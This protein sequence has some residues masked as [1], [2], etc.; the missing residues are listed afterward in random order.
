MFIDLNRVAEHFEGTK[1][2]I[3]ETAKTFSLTT[4]DR[5]E[6]AI[7]PYNKHLLY[8]CTETTPVDQYKFLPHMSLL[9]T[10]R[11]DADF[12][13]IL[14]RFPDN[15]NVM[16]IQAKQDNDFF[17]T[18][19]DYFDLCSG[20]SMIGNTFLEI[21]SF[22][23][24]IQAM[25]DYA[26]LAFD[27]PVFVFDANFTLIAANWEEAQKHPA[28][29]DIINN[30]GFSQKD[31]FNV[32]KRNHIHE[33]V[34]ISEY[35]IHA[36]NEEI[37]YDQLL[38][39]I[40]PQK[41][42]GH[43][44]ISAVNRPFTEHDEKILWVLKR[45][46]DQQMKKDEFIRNTRD[47]H[48]EYFLKDLLDEKIA[49]KK[50]LLDRMN[51]VGSSFGGNIY[52]IVVETARSASTLNTFHIRSEFEKHFPNTKSLIYNG[53]LVFII[54]LLEDHFLTRQQIQ[55]AQNLCIQYGLY[56]GMSNCFQNILELTQYYKQALRAIELGICK[57]KEPYL[58]V[59][60]DYVLDHVRNIFVQKEHV[61]TF[62]HPKMKKLLEYDKVHRSELAYTMYMYLIHERNVSTTA[63]S[64]YMH[65]SSLIYRL[66]KIN[67][68][69]ED[70]FDD[71]K[72]RQY[73]IFSYE[74]NAEN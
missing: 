30:R 21:L 24:G 51:Y 70:D 15:V 3:R 28:C 45:Y 72:E 33:K 64:M 60:Q 9:C 67:S 13:S 35:P 58:Y 68:L 18:L 32:N 11:E 41:D 39:A 40:D 46:I 44:V 19:R 36:Y 38:C 66:K 26:F 7:V 5:L 4:Y 6:Q 12:P 48:Y 56:A 71:Y 17:R 49:T 31:F 25:I 74:L 57:S 47:F 27:N 69:V 1:L 43:V 14:E 55:D 65:R 50:A 42:M 61:L 63:E 16:L 52:C 34:K 2:Y 23:G 29:R 62:C 22:E 53:E 10:V 59:Y 37:G 8:T 73:M 20:V 54:S